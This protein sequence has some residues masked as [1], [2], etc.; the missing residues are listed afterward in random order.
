[1]SAHFD[2]AARAAPESDEVRNEV[3][4]RWE[5]RH[6]D[7]AAVEPDPRATPRLCADCGQTFAWRGYEPLCGWCYDKQ[8]QR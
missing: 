3:F 7:E 6:P 2:R 8:G 5:R 1:V 4:A